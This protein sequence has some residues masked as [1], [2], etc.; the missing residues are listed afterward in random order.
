MFHTSK[1]GWLR[2]SLMGAA[3]LGAGVVT[4]GA[5]SAPANAYYYPYYGGY[6]YYAPYYSAYYPYYGYP[7]YYGYPGF[8]VGFG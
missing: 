5:A 3:F 1:P 4:L 2:R 8:R 6:P 7:S